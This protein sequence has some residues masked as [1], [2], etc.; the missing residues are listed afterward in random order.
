MEKN[1]FS[2]LPLFISFFL[3]VCNTH[4]IIP[5][6]SLSTFQQLGATALLYVAIIYA[7]PH[8]AQSSTMYI[9]ASW[10]ERKHKQKLFVVLGYAGG[11][12]QNIALYFIAPLGL[13]WANLLVTFLGNMI[14]VSYIPGIK[15]YIAHRRVNREGK[16][17]GNFNILQTMGFNIGIL[18]GGLLYDIIGIRVMIIISIGISILALGL[19]IF[20]PNLEI[21]PI[22]LNR[23]YPPQTALTQDTTEKLLTIPP[24]KSFQTIFTAKQALWFQF[25]LTAVSSTFF[26]LFAPYLNQLGEGTWF[27]GVSSV[28]SG[29]LGAIS[30]GIFGKLL[31]RKG[32]NTLY[33][34]AATSYA[35]I[36][37]MLLG[38]QNLVVILIAWSV[39]SYTF[40]IATEFIASRVEDKT[41]AIRSMA[42]AQFARSFGV[43]VGQFI[44]GIIVLNGSY[45]NVMLFSIIACT[46]FVGILIIKTLFGKRYTL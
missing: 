26:G 38:S 43:V 37:M 12:A 5:Y 34:W 2:L 10:A 24:R 17:L 1:E 36:Y 41:I 30:F 6:L 33:W 28:L 3:A 9:F 35:I 46:L 20:I 23:G 27:Y 40:L 11:L 31:D 19:T 14:I 42:W 29:I 4:F 21:T 8:I 7:T 45:Q 25:G 32:P 39:P 15:A 44:G 13:A 18:G 22:G 16:S